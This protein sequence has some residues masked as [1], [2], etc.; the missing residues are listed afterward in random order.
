MP[1]DGIEFESFTIISIDSL[2]VY[3]NIYYLQVY[4]DK[5]AYKIVNTQVEDYLDD[6]PF[7]SEKI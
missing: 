2:L 4:L 5:C 7:E 6:N 3:E 1:K